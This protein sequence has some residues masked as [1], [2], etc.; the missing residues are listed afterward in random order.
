M[1]IRGEDV[2][3]DQGG[4]LA[5]VGRHVEV[6]NGGAFLLVARNV[7]G[8]VNV[9]LDWRGVIAAVVTVTLLRRLLRARRQ[10]GE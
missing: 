2:R 9:A 8:D 3:V 7:S 6:R 5:I 10:A 4:A 1:L